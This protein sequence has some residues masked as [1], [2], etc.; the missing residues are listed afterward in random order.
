MNVERFMPTAQ[1]PEIPSS[2][3]NV[4]TEED[5]A[6]QRQVEEQFK[7]LDEMQ[8][9]ELTPQ[10]PLANADVP[11]GAQQENIAEAIEDSLLDGNEEQNERQRGIAQ[12][13]HNTF[14]R[15]SE[16]QRIQGTENAVKRQRAIEALSMRYFAGLLHQMYESGDAAGAKLLQRLQRLDIAKPSGELDMQ[17]DGMAYLE[18]V[19]R[20]Y[21]LDNHRQWSTID[22]ADRHL[23]AVDVSAHALRD[24]VERAVQGYESTKNAPTS[25][26]TALD[27]SRGDRKDYRSTPAFRSYALARIFAVAHSD[28]LRMQALC[29]SG[30]IGPDGRWK[31]RGLES[32]EA[33]VQHPVIAALLQETMEQMKM[34]A[35]TPDGPRSEQDLREQIENYI[36]HRI[37]GNTKKLRAA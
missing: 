30:A 3:D 1:E 9:Q 5:L 10:T 24:A 16:A 7:K 19:T 32:A 14:Q 27:V 11:V 2:S 34:L 28:D 23:G 29:D 4:P 17:G 26:R 33:R 22:E 37:D 6:R 25:L 21:I 18:G 15:L 8:R 13:M 36:A 12:D 35:T 31:A 20:S